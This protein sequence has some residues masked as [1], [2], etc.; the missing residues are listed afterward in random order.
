MKSKFPAF[1]RIFGKSAVDWY[2][3]WL[4]MTIIGIVWLFAQ[5]TIIL[6]PAVTFGVYYA[7]NNLIRSGENLGV[8]GVLEGARK[9]FLK[10]LGWGALS[11]LV[12]FIVVVNFQFYN[13][14]DT[15]LGLVARIF[16]IVLTMVWLLAQF[17]AV[18]FFMAQEKENI[19]LA[20]R[21]GLYMA[22]ASLPYTVGLM[23][24]VVLII[25]LSSA[26]VIPAFLGLPMLITELSTRALYDRLEAFG[27][28]EKEIDPK[29]VR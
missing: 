25:G 9:Y 16:V 21:N 27:L 17:Y 5:A 3:S 14:L 11:W 28:K 7:V 12:G 23:I 8:K 4:D 20:L 1:L 26:L 29:E 24:F 6:G 15:T 10:S 13:S 18:A 22:L 2:D 19:F